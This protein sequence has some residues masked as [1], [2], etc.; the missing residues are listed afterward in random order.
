[1]RYLF[2]LL[3]A[4]IS[5]SASLALC[6]GED[7]IGALPAETRAELEAHAAAAPYPNGLLWRATRGETQ[8]TWFGTYHFAH[9]QTEAHLEALKPLIEAADAVYL[10]VSNDDQ[11]QLEAEIASDPSIMF[12]TEGPTLPDL[13]GPQDWQ[14]YKDAMFDRAIPGFMAAKFKPMWAAIMLGIGP[15]E[16]RAGVANMKGIDMR[17]GEFAEAIGKPSRSLESYRALLTMMDSFPQDEQ[18]D[19]IRLFFAWT[20]DADDM[21]YTLR[22]RYLAQEV[23]VIWEYSRMISLEFGG[24]TAEEDFALMEELLL[25]KRNTDWIELLLDEAEDKSVFAAVG[26][27][28]LP[29][30]HGVLHLLEQEGFTITPLPFAP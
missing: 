23:G 26:A 27:A 12:I 30:Q 16:A 5:P 20:G 6:E 13:L 9:S 24:P 3:F 2:T 17:I 21:A 29:G 25:I 22:Q 19:M 28:H 15:C 4:L 10:E 14:R 7:L 18:L 1:M 11:A 8:I